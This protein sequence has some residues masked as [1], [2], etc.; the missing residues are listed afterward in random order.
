M[1]INPSFFDTTCA[2]KTRT[3]VTSH[4]HGYSL[5]WLGHTRGWL[6]GRSIAFWGLLNS[7]LFCGQFASC[8]LKR[9]CDAVELVC[10]MYP[11]TF[12]AKEPFKLFDLVPLGMQVTVSNVSDA[13]SNLSSC[14]GI[15]QFK[16]EDIE[17]SWSV[18]S[19]SESLALAN[20]LPQ[21][22]SDLS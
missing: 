10:P 12:L 9:R 6:A 18:N 1:C 11:K 8:F 21:V 7:A 13:F 15:V 14:S 19:T 17:V 22:T 5:Q 4:S 20:P 16:P 3:A 2:G